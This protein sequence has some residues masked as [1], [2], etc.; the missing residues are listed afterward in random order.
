MTEVHATHRVQVL[1]EAKI[2]VQNEYNG[3]KR[4]QKDPEIKE[5]VINY[6]FGDGENPYADIMAIRD[7]K[8]EKI[9]AEMIEILATVQL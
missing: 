1:A 5:Q 9:E 8:L 4:I 7:E 6:I 3:L 2:R